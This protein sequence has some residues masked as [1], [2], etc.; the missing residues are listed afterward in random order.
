MAETIL[1]VWRLCCWTQSFCLGGKVILMLVIG[2]VGE[3]WWMYQY[4]HTGSNHLL[5]VKSYHPSNMESSSLV[6]I[7][8]IG[9][10]QPLHS[11]IGPR[12]LCNRI[13]QVC[14]RQCIRM[15]R[16][17]WDWQ[18]LCSLHTFNIYPDD[19]EKTKMWASSSAMGSQLQQ[20]DGQCWSCNVESH[21]TL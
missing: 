19:E 4:N 13:C 5:C 1:C 12:D 10:A 20:E 8:K 6:T 7:D 16:H 17:V 11:A 2:D 21:F 3:C 18:H 9:S 14:H 15:R